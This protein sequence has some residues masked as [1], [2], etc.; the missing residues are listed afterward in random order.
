[1]KIEQTGVS[2]ALILAALVLCSWFE[3]A[4]AQQ[5]TPEQIAAIRQSCRSDFMS[6]C[7]D[8]QPGGREALLCLKRNAGSVSAPCKAALD[9]VGAKPAA[10]GVEPARAPAANPP[11]PAA[12]APPA[13]EGP[14]PP[15]AAA[16]PHE[17]AQA[18]P[19]PTGETPPGPGP[20]E[21]GMPGQSQVAAV[22]VA[23]RADFGVHC[24]GVKPGGRAALRCL[25]VNAAALSPRCRSAVEAMGEGGG[26]PPAEG[27]TAASSS[28][29][30]RST[31]AGR[32]RAART[33]PAPDAATGDADSVVLR[34]GALGLVR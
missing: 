10:G 24:P 29:A 12:E 16:A 25:Q 34:P 7:A 18:G 15:P 27:A 13:G 33:N 5:P 6:H 9:A 4:A 8:V 30:R 23:C 20:S 28:T 22:R 31:A 11:E 32:R 26:A 3:E 21:A 14:P 2:T 17:P 19:P 1:V